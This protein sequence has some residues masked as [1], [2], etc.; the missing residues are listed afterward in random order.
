MQK[1]EKE[2]QVEEL[3]KKFQSSS[4]VVVADYSTVNVKE[5]TG[6]RRE[7]RKIKAR[8]QVAKNTLTAIAVSG[9]PYEPL[10]NYLSGPVALAFAEGPVEISKILVKF[11]KDTGKLRIKVAFFEGQLVGPELI[12]EMAS[13][14]SKEELYGQLVGNLKAPIFNF[15]F[16]LSGI[17]RNFVYLLS[18]IERTKGQGETNS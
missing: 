15:V 6:L 2:K 17:Y 11:S 8:F 3:K 10:K 7:L 1:L 16:I 14:P 5:V 13:L 12:K 18:E 4:A 9:T